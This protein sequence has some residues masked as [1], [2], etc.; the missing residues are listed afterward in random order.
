MADWARRAFICLKSKRQRTEDDK[1]NFHFVNK[2]F[3]KE[4]DVGNTLA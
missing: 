4:D 2:F 1:D 3:K